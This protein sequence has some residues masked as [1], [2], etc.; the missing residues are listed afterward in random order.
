MD[1]FRAILAAAPLAWRDWSAA[2]RAEAITEGKPLL[3]VCGEA[4]DH[5]SAV[6]AAELAADAEVSAFI[7]EAYLPVAIE[8]LD[9]PV[10]A[11][12]LQEV[13]AC[14]ADAAGFPLVAIA[15]PEGDCV[16]AVPWLPLRDRD[17]RPGLARVL[18]GFA[19]AWST[20]ADALR[21][22]ADG[23]RA[24]I[25]AARPPAT[26]LRADLQLDALE[27]GLVG[28]ADTLEGGFGPAPR[29]LGTSALHFACERLRCGNETL[30]LRRIAER[31]ALAWLQGAACDQ[32][33]GGV[34]RGCSDAAWRAPFAEQ[35]LI[36]QSQAARAW[37]AA[38]EALDQEVLAVAAMRCLRWTVDHLR[39]DDGRFV[40][41]FHADAPDADGR[42]REA[43]HLTWTVAEIEAL[44]GQEAADLI[45]ERFDL[46]GA[47]LIEGRHPLAIRQ[48]LDA[49]E[50]PRLAAALQ[51]LAV[52][53]SERPRPLR[54]ER[55]DR[56][57]EGLLLTA[58]A[59]LRDID[60]TA[61]VPAGEDLARRLAAADPA[62]ARH[63]GEGAAIALGLA[64]WDEDTAAA[65]WLAREEALLADLD[66]DD[67]RRLALDDDRGAAPLA[68]LAE[69]RLALG[70]ADRAR[71][72]IAAHAALLRHPA[73]AGLGR[74]LT[75][76]HHQGIR[77]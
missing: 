51:R 48:P 74:I 61:L 65:R 30:S 15:T 7:A 71:D 36:D 21:R 39:R 70:Q 47:P 32:L 3:L 42:P 31:T 40:A 67:H 27:A 9:Q 77:A 4:C 29:S 41:G 13:L 56:A 25:A 5:W 50:G 26:A 73:A 2:T 38:A 19:E 11:R 14:C 66:D 18:V 64:R 75:I 69:A 6:L 35:R 72:G 57:G 59:D 46:A 22:D 1:P 58:L 37:I 76:L 17:R 49:A 63:P 55:S 12:R 20:D 28:I 54:D 16:G 33:G 53:R 52:A 62:E 23:I 45:A 10:L 8:R 34:H 44:V 60:E 68:I 43:V 24:R